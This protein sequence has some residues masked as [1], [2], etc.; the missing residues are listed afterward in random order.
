[1][2]PVLWS[3]QEHPKKN[4]EEVT[5]SVPRNPYL[6]RLSFHLSVFT[7][8]VIGGSIP[9]ASTKGSYLGVCT[10]RVTCRGYLGGSYLEALPGEIPRGDC[11]ANP[12]PYLEEISGILY[13]G[14]TWNFYL[15]EVI[16]RGYL[17]AFLR[18]KLGSDLKLHLG[19][20]DTWGP[21]VEHFTW[22]PYL[23]AV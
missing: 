15:G 11:R 8:E 5:S 3:L 14:S 21:Y 10:W 16:W 12:G 6:Q 4:E 13:R 2:C 7:W 19:E 9:R 23:I 20:G 18:G 17:G 22:D 1:M